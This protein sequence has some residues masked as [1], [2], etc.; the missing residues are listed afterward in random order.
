MNGTEAETLEE[1]SECKTRKKNR[2][3]KNTWKKSNV[4]IK[5]VD[6]FKLI[7]LLN[8]QIWNN[9]LSDLSYCFIYFNS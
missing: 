6:L 4:L 8:Y 3:K 5:I 1:R 7:I 2:I 9:Y